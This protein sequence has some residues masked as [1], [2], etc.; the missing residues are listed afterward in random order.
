[1]CTLSY[2]MYIS[3]FLNA[4]TAYDIFINVINQYYELI[5]S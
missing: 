5:N 4:N 2:T 3:L 1:M